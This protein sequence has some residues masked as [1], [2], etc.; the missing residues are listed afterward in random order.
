MRI[1]VIRGSSEGC[2]CGFG[3]RHGGKRLPEETSSPE[4]PS[5]VCDRRIWETAGTSLTPG[6]HGSS[7]LVQGPQETLG[8]PVCIWAAFGKEERFPGRQTGSKSSSPAY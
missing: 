2:E 7:P 3:P 5:A 8:S 1:G 6:L 4:P